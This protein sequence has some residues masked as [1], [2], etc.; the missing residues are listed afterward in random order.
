MPG[1]VSSGRSSA[2]PSSQNS[3][4]RVLSSTTLDHLSLYRRSNTPTPPPP[5]PPPPPPITPNTLG[6]LTPGTQSRTP[7]CRPRTNPPPGSSETHIGMHRT[8]LQHR[9]ALGQE[10]R[11]GRY[12][13]AG[14]V[15]RPLG[16]HGRCSRCGLLSVL[17]AVV[18]VS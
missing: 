7:E 1:A 11:L 5:P 2:R 3:S 15:V 8:Y 10:I 9:R 6:N 13:V 17:A 18:K 12:R 14:D 16:R 4:S